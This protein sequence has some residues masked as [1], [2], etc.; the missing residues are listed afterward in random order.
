MLIKD[1]DCLENTAEEVWQ[2]IQD[3]L[4]ELKTFIEKY[5]K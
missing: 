2:I 5:L 1:L 3:K 4:P